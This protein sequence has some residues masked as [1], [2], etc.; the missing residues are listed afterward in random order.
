MLF[1]YP[2]RM[3]YMLF[4]KWCEYE[5]KSNRPKLPIA[6]ATALTI[7]RINL[8]SVFSLVPTETYLNTII[9]I[10]IACVY[11]VFMSVIAYIANWIIWMAI[12][13]VIDYI[14]REE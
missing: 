6:V 9:C 13:D 5:S 3:I 14:K 1:F 4:K 12:Y 10:L 2:E 7:K 8:L 11:F